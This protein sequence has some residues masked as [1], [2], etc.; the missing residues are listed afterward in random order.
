MSL[1]SAHTLPACAAVLSLA[2]GMA[3]ADPARADTINVTSDGAAYGYDTVTL[4]DSAFKFPN[5]S[6]S[7]EVYSG[8]DLLGGTDLTTSAA[9]SEVVF[10]TDVNNFLTSDSSYTFTTGLLSATVTDPNKVAQ[11][12]ALISNG[13]TLLAGGSYGG[14][15]ATEISSGLQLAVWAAEYQTSDSGN[16]VEDSSQGFWVSG[17]SNGTDV[18]LADA[19]LHDVNDGSSWLGGST[20]ELMPLDPTNNQ[21]L[22]YAGVLPTGGEPSPVPEPASLMLLGVGAAALGVTRRRRAAA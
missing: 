8:A 1:R 22:T 17:P 12:D 21:N 9:F 19:Y 7:V 13:T 2:C 6:N 18:T 3:L 5:G 14:Y 15:T 20:V 16:N 10:C 11:I 4:N